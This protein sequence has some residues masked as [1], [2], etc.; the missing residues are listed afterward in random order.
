VRG[1]G[2]A[3]FGATTLTAAGYQDVFVASLGAD[4][5]A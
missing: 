4:G 3:S 2:N 5:S 1:R